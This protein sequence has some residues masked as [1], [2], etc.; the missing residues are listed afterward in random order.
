[1]VRK[2]LRKAETAQYLPW[3]SVFPKVFFIVLDWEKFK[4]F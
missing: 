4:F 3:A 2:T 1:M